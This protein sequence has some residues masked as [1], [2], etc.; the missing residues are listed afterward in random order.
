MAHVWTPYGFYVN[1]ALSHTGVNAFTFFK[2]DDHWGII[3]LIDIQR[4]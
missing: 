1:G 4:K 3:H 2:K